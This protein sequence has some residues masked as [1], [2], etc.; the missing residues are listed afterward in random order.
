VRDALEH[1]R[2]RFERLELVLAELLVAR[3][4]RLDLVPE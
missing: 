3:L 1:V 4:E 2:D